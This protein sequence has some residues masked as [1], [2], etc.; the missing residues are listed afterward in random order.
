MKTGGHLRIE[1]LGDKVMGVRLFGSPRK[2]EPE[3]FRLEFPGGVI[4]LE[5][6]TDGSY[7]AHV[8]CNQREN[9]EQREGPQAEH[10]KP[11]SH[12]SEAR[13]HMVTKHTSEA[14]LGDFENPGLYDVALR[15]E[16]QSAE[17]TKEEA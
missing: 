14:D 6:C 11:Y 17:R 7:W 16:V 15:I 3:S 10:G 13:L 8:I 9:L 4:D 2:P 5:R 1:Q 12:F